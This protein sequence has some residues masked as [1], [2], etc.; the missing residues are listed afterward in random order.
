MAHRCVVAVKHITT[1][2]APPTLG[3]S[4]TSSIDRADVRL[5]HPC[6]GPEETAGVLQTEVELI[7]EVERAVPCVTAPV[8]TLGL[9]PRQPGSNRG[10]G[11]AGF[12]ST[13][14]RCHHLRNTSDPLS[15][16]LPL[17]TSPCHA[18][19]KGDERGGPKRPPQKLWVPPPQPQG[20]PT[21]P[22]APVQK[23]RFSTEPR[24]R[25]VPSTG[26]L[27]SG[28]IESPLPSLMEL[29]S[30][31]PCCGAK[32]DQAPT[33]RSRAGVAMPAKYSGPRHWPR[34]RQDHAPAAN[35]WCAPTLQS[36]VQP[37]SDRRAPT[38]SF[39]RSCDIL[40]RHCSSNASCKAAESRVVLFTSI[41]RKNKLS[42]FFT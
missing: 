25:S 5:V 29:F 2:R 33:R 35:D 21:P 1:C 34:R 40:R 39:H 4:A 23:V 42:R 7:C 10:Q 19:A 24:S 32:P 14:S 36:I 11:G 20:A 15:M 16:R 12:L 9:I 38:A 30:T 22:A 8:G 27:V 28:R 18:Q 6:E 3:L 31:A 13:S 17:F 37:T 26:P 41:T